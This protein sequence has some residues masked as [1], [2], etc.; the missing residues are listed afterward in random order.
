MSRSLGFGRYLGLAQNA[1]LCNR[2]PVYGIGTVT[3][4]NR[5]SGVV[6]TYGKGSDGQL[7]LKIPM[8]ITVLVL[9]PRRAGGV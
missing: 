2:Q 1:E 8:L 7:G 3:I 5:Y 6:I 4:S 9:N